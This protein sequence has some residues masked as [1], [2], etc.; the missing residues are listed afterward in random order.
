MPVAEVLVTGQRPGSSGIVS[1]RGSKDGHQ[2]THD[3]H[4]RYQQAVYDGNCYIRGNALG[5]PVTT[6]AGLSATT[7]VLTRFSPPNSGK[8]GVLW[9]CTVGVNSAPSAATTVS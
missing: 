8:L 4:A 7:P 9:V 2:L 5:T 3:A 1:Q 6:A